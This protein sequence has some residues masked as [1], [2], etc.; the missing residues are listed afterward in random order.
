MLSI[1]F[2]T[3]TALFSNMVGRCMPA[4]NFL[5]DKILFYLPVFLLLS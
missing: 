1:L 2:R 3:D 5:E 4:K